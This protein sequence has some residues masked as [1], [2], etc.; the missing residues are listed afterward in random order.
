VA[1]LYTCIYSKRTHS[2]SKRPHSNTGGYRTCIYSKRTHSSSKRTHSNTGG[3]R[4]IRPPFSGLRRL[5][6]CVCMCVYIYKYTAAFGPLFLA[7]PAS[8]DCFHVAHVPVYSKKT[9][10]SS[11]RTHSS[12]KRTHS[13]VPRLR[14]LF[15]CRARTC[16]CVCGYGCVYINLYIYMFVCVCVC[17]CVVLHTYY[18]AHV[19]IIILSARC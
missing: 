18:T 14:R 17:V 2:S 15:S 4:G 1:F 7:D 19:L 10:S 16:I 13:S 11:K 12:I 5:C 8:E 9:Y 6:V 3:Y